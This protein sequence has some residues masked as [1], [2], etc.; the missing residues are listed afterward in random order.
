MTMRSR[1]RR[2]R[3]ATVVAASVLAL[4]AA[5]TT[6]TPPPTATTSAGSAP[7]SATTA[8]TT[9]SA[10]S[11]ADILD[12]AKANAIKATSAAF[13]GR[14][15]QDGAEMLVDFK[16]TSNG[17]TSDL[18][19]TTVDQGRVRV[20]SVDGAVYLQADEKFW[21]A[22]GV[23]TAF[24]ADRF[25]K[26]P[27]VAAQFS[28]EFSL[29]ALIDE[30]LAAVTASQLS[31]T[32]G[33]EMVGGTDTWVITDSAGPGEGALYVSKS[34]YQVVRFTGSSKSPAQLDFSQWNADLGIVAPP[35]HQV[36]SLD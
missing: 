1:G 25:V 28:E 36:V 29:N 33:S 3:A 19:M 13:T 24:P 17:S 31:D 14:V 34:D 18:T 12:R 4:G 21:T 30:A 9:A 23:P 10:P 27:A 20:L 32:V 5:C 26:V 35:K 16:G 8:A 15:Q 22:Q 6:S 2:W 7:A 11:A